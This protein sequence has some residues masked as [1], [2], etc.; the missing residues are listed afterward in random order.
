M[1]LYVRALR[2]DPGAFARNPE[3]RVFLAIIGTFTIASMLQQ[4]MA[5]THTGEAA[6]RYA[7]FNVVTLIT[8][9][10]FVTVDYTSWGALSDALFFIVLFLGGCTGSTSG[11]L[12]SFR[13]AILSLST[14]H[15]FEKVIHPHGVKPLRYGGQRVDD[16]VV[17]AVFAFVFV[18]A[19][20]FLITATA[21]SLVGYDLRTA[22]SASIA[23][24]ANVGPG[25]GPLV[26]P[27]VNWSGLDNLSIWIL[28]VAMLLGR[29]EFFTIL[30]LLLPRFW[31]G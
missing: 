31:R 6:F 7:L 21:L 9:T 19:A 22:M 2:G 11:G 3:I 24:L 27:A 30:V 28:T 16:D 14:L 12:K 18:Y 17:S 8:T 13:I 4:M 25:L 20:W 5:G 10:G 1:V 29:L 26:G 15:Q 23:A